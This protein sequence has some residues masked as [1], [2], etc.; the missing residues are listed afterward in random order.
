MIFKSY[1]T[2]NNTKFFLDNNC[3]LFYGENL[4]QKKDFKSQIKNVNKKSTF[5][6]FSQEEV[7]QNENILNNEINNFSLFLE[8]KIIFIENITDKFL[9]ILESLKDNISDNKIILFSDILE[10]K[11]KIRNYFEKSKKLQIVACY[12][13]N[14]LTIRKI[15]QKRLKNFKGLSPH[16]IN[17]IVNQCNL[18]RIKLNNELDKIILYFSDKTLDSKKLEMLLDVNVNEDFNILKDEA[19]L[20]NKFKTN[21]LLSDTNLENDKSVY[22]LTLINQRLYKLNSILKISSNSNL[23]DAVNTFKPPIFWKEK[24][25]ILAQL[26]KWNRDKIKFILDSTY[27]L[28]IK[29]KSNS[30]IGKNI[31]M[32]K[33]ILEIC[34]LANA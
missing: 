17:L 31:L 1:L 19:L 28:E 2:E 32:K 7:L 12:P 33:L 15:I 30:S 8:K 18:E 3:I 25:N 5:L 20:G 6:N 23:E 4:G 21:K 34:D 11:S 22:Y 27:N 10:K 9:T 29:I 14:E 24:E 16:N 26:N 13:D